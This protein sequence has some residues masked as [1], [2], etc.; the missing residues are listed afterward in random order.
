[1]RQY[2]KCNHKGKIDTRSRELVLESLAGGQANKTD[3]S[4]AYGLA[5]IVK[6]GWHC[7]VGV[8]SLDRHMVRSMLGARVQLIGMRV[9]VTNQIRGIFKTLGIVL[10]RRT[11]GSP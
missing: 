3:K 4:N 9:E 5:Q 7:E 6:A 2:H 1:L 8:K 10:S 11:G